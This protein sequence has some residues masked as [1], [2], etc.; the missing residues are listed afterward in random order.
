MAVRK[1]RKKSSV[2]RSYKAIKGFKRVEALLPPDAAAALSKLTAEGV[3]T[4][5]TIANAII[6]AAKMKR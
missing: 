6:E 4:S 3:S 2:Y 1:K 5:K